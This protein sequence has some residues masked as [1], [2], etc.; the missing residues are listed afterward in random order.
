[1]KANF[2]LTASL[3]FSGKNLIEPFMFVADGLALNY[4]A[5]GFDTAANIGNHYDPNIRKRLSRFSE[6]ILEEI[7]F[8]HLRSNIEFNFGKRRRISLRPSQITYSNQDQVLRY[9]FF[10]QEQHNGSI[11]TNSSSVKNIKIDPVYFA[12]ELKKIV[13]LKPFEEKEAKYAEIPGTYCNHELEIS[14]DWNFIREANSESLLRKTISSKN[15]SV[16]LQ[17]FLSICSESDLNIFAE[18]MENHLSYLLVHQYGNFLVQRLIVKHKSTLKYIRDLVKQRFPEF[19]MNEHSSRLIEVLIQRCKKFRAFSQLYFTSNFYDSISCNAA[20][21]IL[22]ACLKMDQGSTIC[23]MVLEYLHQE[24]QLIRNKFF[25]KLVNTCISLGS[26]HH[27]D[28]VANWLDVSSNFCKLFERKWSACFVSSLIE[29]NHGDTIKA[30]LMQLASNTRNL[31]EKSLFNQYAD[32]IWDDLP[33][34]IL[35]KAIL[36]LM[37]LRPTALSKLRKNIHV[38]CRYLLA[39]ISAHKDPQNEMLLLFLSRPDI[40]NAFA[41]IMRDA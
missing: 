2:E 19:I 28:Q 40:N 34:E 20:C 12:S 36:I 18:K 31:F 11:P 23:D 17:S 10:K 22:V 27:L 3:P 21:L 29:R 35:K 13:G 15:S 41:K 6:S 33:N 8:N 32:K 25:R 5:Q 24:P 16:M 9:N 4:R 37:G 38:F 30:F 1:M 26:Q 14:I 39:I 7:D